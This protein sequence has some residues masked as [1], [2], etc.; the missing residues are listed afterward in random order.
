MDE[1]PKTLSSMVILFCD[2][3]IS[4]SLNFPK[5]LKRDPSIYKRERSYIKNAPG[6]A[7]CCI[8]I[9]QRKKDIL[10]NQG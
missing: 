1:N 9:R 6:M 8:Q 5:D 3:F 7:K 10:N 2:R 4:V